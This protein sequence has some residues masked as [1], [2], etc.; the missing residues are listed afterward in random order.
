MRILVVEDD[1]RMAAAI[2]RGL[3]WEG[4][5]AD[6]AAGGRQAL[7]MT[8]AT[9]YDAVVLDVMLGD[10]DGFATCRQMRADGMWAPIIMLTAREGIEDGVRASTRGPT[11]T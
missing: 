7:A 2:R 1:V 6:V 8:A 11:T 10:L 5:V 9:E 4:L 3:R